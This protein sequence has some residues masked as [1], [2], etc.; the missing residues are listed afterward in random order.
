[1]KSRCNGCRCV[2]CRWK[3]AGANCHDNEHGAELSRCSWCQ[4]HTRREEL[5]KMKTDSYL[6]LGY[7]RRYEGKE[8]LKD[9]KGD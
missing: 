1:M 3:G 8:A 9:G 5:T 7:Q 4:N 6:C 2:T